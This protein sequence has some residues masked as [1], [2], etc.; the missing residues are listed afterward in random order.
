VDVDSRGQPIKYHQYDGSLYLR[1]LSDAVYTVNG[2]YWKKITKL[3]A[4]TDVSMFK[5]DWDEVIQL[6]AIYRAFRKLGEFERWNII[7]N[8]F[9]AMVRSRVQEEDVEQ[10]PEGSINPYP[11]NPGELRTGLGVDDE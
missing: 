10:F 8:E 1:P 3:V 9:L 6:G 7:R 11:K 2:H 4:K 5:D